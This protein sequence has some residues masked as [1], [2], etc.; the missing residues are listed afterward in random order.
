[1]AGFSVS[2][3][4]DTKAMLRDL[5]RVQRVKVP[6][7]VPSV[8]NQIAQRKVESQAVKD[9]AAASGFAQGVIR[10]RHNAW[11][12]RTGKRR[13]VLA[14]ATA[15]DWA[16][17]WYW[18]GK[19][20]RAGAIT[21]VSVPGRRQTRAGVKAGAHSVPGGFIQMSSR[22]GSP[23]AAKRVGRKRYPIEVLRI[24]IGVRADSIF[25]RYV[26]ASGPH[27]VRE[28]ERRIEKTLRTR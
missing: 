4:A 2:V 20:G 6:R 7:L 26:G 16:A 13:L 24:P 12:Q 3:Q 17:R 19:R 27:F 8:L 14:K 23:I 22:S 10:W 21:L 15:K 11:G 5:D 9:V 25:N 18:S 1:V 28:L